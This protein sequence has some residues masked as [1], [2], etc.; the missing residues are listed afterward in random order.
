M[1]SDDEKL[2]SQTLAGDWEVF[3]VLVHKYQE[4]VYASVNTVKG[5]LYRTRQQLG[6]AL[7]DRY[8]SLLKSHKLK[9]SFL[10][11]FMEQ[12][13][14]ISSPTIALSWSVTAI[15]K[16]L[17]F[18][19]MAVCVLNG[20][21]G[22]TAAAENES[23]KAIFSGRVIDNNG[24]PVAN[25]GL[26]YAVTFYPLEGN[27]GSGY[28]SYYDPLF[29]TRT[30]VDGT[31]RFELSPSRLKWMPFDS[32]DMLSHLNIAVTHPDHAIWWQEVPFQ[33]T[34]DMEI[35]LE[36]PE[37][38]S[39]KV[40]NEAG[41]PIQNAKI[42]I[43]SVFRGDPIRG[44]P[45]NSLT[46]DALPQPV[47]TDANG[48]FVFPGLPQ[49]ATI[50]LDVQGSGY[51]KESRHSVSVGA[52]R[53]EFRLKREGR[54]EGRL[55]YAGTGKRV[56]SGVIS[57][58]GI[59]PTRGWGEARV[60]W[61]GNYRL[62]NVIPGTYS[63]YFAHGPEGWTAIAK[64]P[65]TVS[66]GETVTV[67]LTLIRSGTISGQ[68]TDQDTNEPIANHPIRLN[69]AARPE[70]FSL[71]GHHTITDTTGTYRFDAAPGR[72]LVHTNPPG[73]YQD[74][75]QL[76]RSNIGQI[77]RRVDIVEGETVVVNFQF[78]R[79]LKLAGRVL[80]E[81][82]ELVVGA[83][84]SNTRDRREV[85]SIS[86]ASGRFTIGGLR[87]GQKLS[88]KA[89]HSGLRLRGMVEIEVEP[90][91]PIEI[92]MKSYGRVKVS[93]RVVDH[94]G[95]PMSSMDVQLIHW[96]LQRHIGK[97]TNVAV[98]DDDGRFRE[99]E[100]IVGDEYEIYVELEGYRRA[101]TKR[102]AATAEVTQIAD[103]VLSAGGEFFIEGRVTDTSG[104]PVR[105]VQLGISQ[106][107][108]HWSR[109]T[110]PNG[111]YR[112]KDL[113]MAV[114]FRLY[115][116]DPR[117][118]QHEFRILKTNQR[119]D[120][121]LVKADGYLAGKVVDADGKPI[122]RARVMIRAKADPSSGY[123]YFPTNTS[124]HGEF[125]LRHIKDS[126]VSLHVSDRRHR[127]IF[128]DIAVNQ[129]D[130]VFALTSADA[131]PEPTPAQQAERSYSQACRERFKTLV[132]QPAPELS[133][134]EW[135][136]GSPIS[137]GD[138]N[139][140]TVALH[141]WTLNHIHHVQ[142]IRLLNILQEVYRDRGL[143][144]VAICPSTA[145]AEMLQQHIAAESLSYSVGLDRSIDIVGAEGET[146]D[147]Y[148][149][150]WGG[151]IVLI[152]TAGEI[153]GNA[154]AYE[155]EDKIQVLLTD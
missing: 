42:Q 106:G 68:V 77:Q 25:A 110:D 22:P 113:S 1:R 128:K 126:V 100:L 147:R 29:F 134:A 131:R 43:Q 50:S 138:L 46:H 107:G 102:F 52:K 89:E 71:M 19:T 117:Y 123:R 133:V 97:V 155:Y 111:N 30:G 69:D 26:R 124:V 21:Q 88:L 47:K 132:N 8:S 15:G 63:L 135:L 76:E 18:L 23:E 10:M 115:I 149:I 66:E 7:S 118:A 121:V 3:G 2:V 12:I 92:R 59:H 90:D 62:K 127:K 56:R 33:S 98:T 13:H 142:Q 96:D 139:G 103:L 112:L 17:L 81:T 150:G 4:M 108:Q 80:T 51:A 5:K 39:G 32:K 40:M 95:N 20:A 85:Y 53:L 31:F 94:T 145:A 35:Q 34:T 14:H 116:Y 105:G 140:K 6:N 72:A 57:F 64:E 153:V 9:G 144:C 44:E 141:F 61:W 74:I 152:N 151:E 86:D 143:V 84:V 120:L 41:E 114:V 65:I 37:I 75:R 104:E 99:I 45:G 28:S 91:V 55:T 154:W 27:A 83:R 48:E 119:H 58:Q 67:D 54:I 101:E 137:I 82:G 109:R 122:E 11:Q 78:S 24:T 87:I 60:N 16:I 130:L 148:A 146:F 73:G 36:T 125:E 70:D 136:S 49:G 79:G 129:R 93:G 38:I